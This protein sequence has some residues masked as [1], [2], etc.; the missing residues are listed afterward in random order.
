MSF[1]V[2]MC[3]SLEDILYV[4]YIWNDIQKDIITTC[5]DNQLIN[6]SWRQLYTYLT[7]IIA[8]SQR[9]INLFWENILLMYCIIIYKWCFIY[10]FCACTWSTSLSH[11]YY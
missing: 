5:V 9:Y 8:N 10:L 4:Y 3:T 6:N 7:E 2:F 1:V 11:K